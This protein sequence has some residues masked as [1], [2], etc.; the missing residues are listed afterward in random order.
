MNFV[1]RNAPMGTFVPPNSRT[2]PFVPD[3]TRPTSTYI[4]INFQ[5]QALEVREFLLKF[6]PRNPLSA[7]LA[8]ADE[9]VEE[10]QAEDHL[11]LPKYFTQ[12]QEVANHRRTTVVIELDDVAQMFPGLA[13]NIM[14]NTHHYFEL[15][16]KVIDAIMPSESEPIRCW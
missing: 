12:L 2:K 4:P 13:L 15:F 8:D 6:R 9:I 1:G 11:T 10:L 16:S 14:L 3:L 5:A 7:K